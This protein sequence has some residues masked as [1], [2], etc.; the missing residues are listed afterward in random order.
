[1]NTPF[2]F[3]EPGILLKYP[4]DFFPNK[5]MPTNKLLNSVMRLGIYA[6]IVLSTFQKAENG[7]YLCIFTACCTYFL[8][9]YYD[10]AEYNKRVY[11]QPTEKNPYMNV[12]LTDSTDEKC[13][14]PEFNN[15]YENEALTQNIQDKMQKKNPA[16]C[17]S[18]V[19]RQFYT[20]P[21]STI[22]NDRHN[23]GQWLYRKEDGL[24]CKENNNSL[25]EIPKQNVY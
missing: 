6:G 7:L 16:Y 18:H 2:W 10:V 12:L 22:V 3:E 19:Q 8:Y 13:A 4:D 9:K 25:C 11:R 24:T 15:V 1:M 14:E 17:T 5:K 21:V 23:L 20:M